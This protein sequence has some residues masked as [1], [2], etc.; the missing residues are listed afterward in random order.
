MSKELGR[1][2][3]A[4]CCREGKEGDWWKEQHK[5]CTGS[6]SL[7]SENYVTCDCDC[8][9]QSTIILDGF[10]GSIVKVTCG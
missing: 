3:L 6:H 4:P 9:K 1:T 10:V 7:D 5:Y 8:H 2:T